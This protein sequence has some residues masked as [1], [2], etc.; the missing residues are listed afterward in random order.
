MEAMFVIQDILLAIALGAP[1]LDW[2]VEH[3]TCNWT[4]RCGLEKSIVKS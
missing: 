4:R 3:S 1:A 2:C